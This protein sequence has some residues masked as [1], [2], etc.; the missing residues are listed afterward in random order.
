MNRFF[1]IAFNC[2]FESAIGIEHSSIYIYNFRGY[3]EFYCYGGGGSPENSRRKVNL[4]LEIRREC[5]YL[6]SIRI[7]ISLLYLK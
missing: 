1:G 6:K 4:A 5:G 2:E 7:M 3:T